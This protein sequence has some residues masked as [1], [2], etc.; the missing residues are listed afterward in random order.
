MNKNIAIAFLLSISLSATAEIPLYQAVPFGEN[1]PT[2]INDRGQVVGYAEEG[3]AFVL[4]NGMLK[5]LGTLGGTT[6]RAN[7]NNDLG[8]ITG[9]TAL[10]RGRVGQA[11]LYKNGVMMDLGVAGAGAAIN[12]NDQITGSLYLSPN[13]SHA[14]IYSNG[15]LTD[16]GTLGG[17]SSSGS[18]INAS[19]HVIGDAQTPDSLSY[20]H[21]FLYSADTGMADLGA[22]I[23]GEHASAVEITDSGLVSGTASFD[24]YGRAYIYRYRDAKL[25]VLHTLGGSYS[26]AYDINESGEMVGTSI[27]SNGEL[28]GFVYRQGKM[29]DMGTL[30]GIGSYAQFIND[31]GIAVGQVEFAAEKGEDVRAFV[32]TRSGRMIDLNAAVVPREG[33]LFQTVYGINN[34]GQITVDECKGDHCSAYMLTPI[35]LLFE[36]LIDATG[37]VSSVTTLRD[38]ASSARAVY[39]ERRLNPTCD[40]VAR[41]VVETKPAAPP[42]EEAIPLFRL[43]RDA[44]A[45]GTALGCPAL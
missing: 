4:R 32:Y 5:Y 19:G 22:L 26:I 44:R 21:G 18:R 20:P 8:H 16:L 15:A 43:R 35:M 34:L 17:P 39:K 30:G 36:N 24:G 29:I 38:T 23:G 14:F 1:T 9:G 12:N 31:R 6:S 27:T 40:L 3:E 45:I 7:A 28:H 25:T 2:G 13:V 33:Q 10:A 42:P 41:F 11:F 37:T